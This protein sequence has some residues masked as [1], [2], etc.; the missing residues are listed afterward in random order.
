MITEIPYKDH[1]EWLL[2]RRKYIGGSEAGA[3]VGLDSYKSPFSLW[4]EKTGRMPE[5]KGNVTT[6]VGAYLEDLVAHMFSEETGKRVRRKNRTVVNDTY[7]WA[8][9]NVDR[10]ISGESSLLEIKT[11]NS[12]P[13]MKKIKNG[14]YPERWYCQMVHYL[15][16]TGLQKA[17][18]AVLVNCRELRIFELERDESEIAALMAAEGEFWNNHVLTDI[19]PA[20]DGNKVTTDAVNEVFALTDND[21]VS[22]V[23]FENELDRYVAIGNQIKELKILQDE[24]ANSVKIKM[25]EA[26]NGESNRWT[27]KWTSSERMSF[28]SKSFI[29]E[30][31]ETDLDKYIKTTKVRTFRVTERKEA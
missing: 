16:V 28:D 5:F 7:P 9:A 6:K 30:H 24:A 22:L 11:T 21:T 26:C 18:L 12:P 3:V 1:E 2:L 13:A 15:A 20:A 31:K 4:A 19:P 8:C 14:E 25:G 29:E 17:Y 10:M 23:Q 27:V